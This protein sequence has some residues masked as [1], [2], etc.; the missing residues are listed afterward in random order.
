VLIRRAPGRSKFITKSLCDSDHL[1]ASLRPSNRYCRC[2][3]AELKPKT[4]FARTFGAPIR[5]FTSDLVPSDSFL[6]F[7]SSSDWTW[8]CVA[9]CS[10]GH[11]TSPHCKFVGMSR[12]GYRHEFRPFYRPFLQ[13]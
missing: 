8:K 13:L 11:P 2:L 12:S 9:R 1:A 4:P 6:L 5:L 3:L 7:R 10:A